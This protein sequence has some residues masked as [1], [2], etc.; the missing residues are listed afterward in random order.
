[1]NLD[2]FY[3]TV[4]YLKET[5]EDKCEKRTKLMERRNYSYF[6]TKKY[7]L[8]IKNVQ[9][10]YYDSPNNDFYKLLTQRF[11]EKQIKHEH[12]WKKFNSR[13]EKGFMLLRPTTK[14]VSELL[15]I[16]ERE[17][18]YLLNCAKKDTQNNE[19]NED[20]KIT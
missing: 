10:S 8:E 14:V 7:S 18:T 13:F 19:E 4:Q 15:G 3:N 9:D 16:C 2:T 5:F 20:K 12:H 1:M 17:V 6:H 11:K